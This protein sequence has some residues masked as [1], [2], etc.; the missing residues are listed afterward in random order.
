MMRVYVYCAAFAL[1][2]TLAGCATTPE[3]AS[4]PARVLAKAEEMHCLNLPG[5]PR[6]LPPAPAA[7]PEAAPLVA[8]FRLPDDQAQLALCRQ[9]NPCNQGLESWTNLRPALAA[10]MEYLQKLRDR[11]G[12]GPLTPRKLRL[13]AARLLSLLET[14]DENPDLLRQ[15][16][17][18]L[19]LAVK[20][21]M[22]GYYTPLLDASLRQG[23]GY[24]YPLYKLPPELEGKAAPGQG[25]KGL[26]SAKWSREAIDFGGA[27]A[28]RGLELAWARNRVDLFNLHVQGAGVLALPDGS[29]RRVNYAGKNGLPFTGLGAV[30]KQLNL[31]PGE[32]IILR[33]MRAHL[34]KHPERERELL[35]RNQ[36]YVFFQL[37][38]GGSMGTMGAP[39]TPRVSLATDPAVA[40][41]GAAMVFEAARL[42]R[43]GG[44]AAALAGLGLAQDTGGV[45][46]GPRVDFFW[47]E[48]D[49]VERQAMRTNTSATVYFL[50][51]K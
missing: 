14:M 32:P 37:L 36:S 34:Q 40:P 17:V 33:T 41:L 18:W 45:I 1:L 31:L 38:D 3:P 35:S 13:A 24:D 51:A 48:G 30:F 11:P 10:N 7:R 2:L 39:L 29:R 4:Q 21:S 20:A 12:P 8:R 22:T 5:P 28:H 46:K 26:D 15:E 6:P 9:L 42:P 47:G 16:F 49:R 27:L 43:E 19:E 50:V 25:P 44:G 23:G